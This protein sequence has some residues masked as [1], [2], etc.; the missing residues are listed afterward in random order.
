MQRDRSIGGPLTFPTRATIACSQ[1]RRAFRMVDAELP[2][3]APNLWKGPSPE[4]AA[5]KAW[6]ANKHMVRVELQEIGG[7]GQ[8]FVF[9]TNGFKLSKFGL[10]QQA[11]RASGGRC[12]DRQLRKMEWAVSAGD[13]DNCGAESGRIT[14]IDGFVAED[15]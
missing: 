15:W 8:I 3:G 5:K 13:S 7:S 6:R 12:A 2:D 14:V 11:Q 4:A 10:Q 9:D 1:P